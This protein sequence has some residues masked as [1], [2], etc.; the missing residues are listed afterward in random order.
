MRDF[1][2]EVDLVAHDDLHVI[3]LGIVNNYALSKYDMYDQQGRFQK[4]SL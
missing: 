3:S 2:N 4:I 1:V